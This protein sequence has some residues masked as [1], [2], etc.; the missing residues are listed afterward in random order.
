IEPA[1][2]EHPE[3]DVA[4]E[5][6]LRR[7]LEPLPEV[8]LEVVV[9]AALVGRGRVDRLPVAADGEPVA[10]EGRAR[11]GRKLVDLREGGEPRGDV[12]EAQIEI[13]RLFV[14]LAGTVGSQSSDLISLPKTSR[15]LPRW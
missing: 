3:R 6:D 1:G 4:H 11:G 13:E 5:A 14:E 9:V 12:T 2:E 7:V 15:S 10:V 8:L